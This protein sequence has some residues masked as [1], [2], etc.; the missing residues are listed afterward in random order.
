MP[1]RVSQKTSKI[2]IN[3]GLRQPDLPVGTG[4][5]L[6]LDDWEDGKSTVSTGMA[7]DDFDTTPIGFTE[8]SASFETVNTRFAPDQVIKNGSPLIEFDVTSPV[9]SGTY[10]AWCAHGSSSYSSA[11]IYKPGEWSKVSSTK[12]WKFFIRWNVSAVVRIPLMC[13]SADGIE[14]GEVYPSTGYMVKINLGG[15]NNT[16]LIYQEAGSESIICT[17]DSNIGI[18]TWHEMI[19]TRDKDALWEF[20]IVGEGT[21]SGTEN[22]LENGDW[23]GGICRDQ[24]NTGGHYIDNLAIYDY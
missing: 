8:P 4:N 17:P 21:A 16:H 14:S 15:I 11:F 7:R 18:D 12:V 23:A 1:V 5:G 13:V 2:I 10:C 24:G 19:V 9:Y 6:L 20:Q 22:S 3:P